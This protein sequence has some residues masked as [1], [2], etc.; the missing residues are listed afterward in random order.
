MRLEIGD[1]HS[2]DMRL[3]S[4]FKRDGTALRKFQA[5]SLVGT[6]KRRQTVVEFDSQG[7]NDV[8]NGWEEQTEQIALSG[9]W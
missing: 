7:A 6:S 3:T 5:V 4:G 9:K 2:V 8:D 1:G